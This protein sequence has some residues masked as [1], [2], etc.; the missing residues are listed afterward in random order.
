[1]DQ[2]TLSTKLINKVK[3]FHIPLLGKIKDPLLWLSGSRM[4]Q[5]TSYLPFSLKKG[6]GTNGPTFS[7]NNGWCRC[8]P[9]AHTHTARTHARTHAH[10][11]AVTSD[12]ILAALCRVCRTSWLLVSYH[13][14]NVVSTSH[15]QIQ[16]GTPTHPPTPT[17]RHRA[18]KTETETETETHTTLAAD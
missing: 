14:Q 10:T 8:S 15:P 3:L 1:M 12:S 9:D 16:Q 18:I 5:H 11:L 17:R 2:T 13:S 4:S 6:E 7:H